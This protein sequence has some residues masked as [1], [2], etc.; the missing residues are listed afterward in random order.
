M[1]LRKI[2]KIKIRIVLMLNKTKKYDLLT[3]TLLNNFIFQSNV[4]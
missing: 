2:L 3:D 4:R 1:L